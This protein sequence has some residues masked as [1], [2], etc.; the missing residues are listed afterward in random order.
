MNLVIFGPPGAGKGTQG[1]LL[2]ER[3]GLLRLSTGDLL[4]EAV[5]AGT[6]LGTQAQRFMNAGELVPDSVILGLVRETMQDN[7]GAGVIF[8]GFPRTLPQAEA[9][10][11]LLADLGSPI[12]AV[13][14]L[15]VKDEALVRRISGRRSCSSCNAVYNVYSD[16]P[17][18]EGI[19]DHCGANLVQRSD[20]EEA[21]VRRRLQVYHDQTAPLIQYY[22]AS[23]A[24][25]HHINGDRPIAAV[26]ADLLAAL[27]R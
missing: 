22:E 4:R 21:T 10:D 13:L 26:Q 3:Q 9:L 7:A 25:V 16:K 23:P 1:A 27:P 12:A 18:T 5:R 24:P 14:V 11:A 15:N 17:K 8:D 2:A 6:P 20:D 19:C